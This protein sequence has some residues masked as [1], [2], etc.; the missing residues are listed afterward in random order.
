MKNIIE[1]YKTHCDEHFIDFGINSSVN[2]YDFTTLFCPAGMQ[3]YKSNFTDENFVAT[4]ANVQSCIRMND[5]DEIGDTTHLLYFNMIGLFSFR[6]LSVQQAIDFWM[7]FLCEKLELKLSYATIHPECKDWSNYYSKY[8]LKVKYQ[9]DCTWS[10]GDIGGYCTEL[11]IDEVE[12][13]NIV[14]PM[15]TCIDVGFGLERLDFF[16]NGKVI[17]KE[18]TL[19]ESAEKIISSGFKPSNTKQG[20]V[21][22][23][24]LREI[25]SLGL[26][27][28][29]SYFEQEVERQNKIKKKYERL[30]IRYPDESKEWWFDT[31]GVNI[32]D[33]Y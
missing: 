23:K 26:T 24:L 29:H 1:L 19:L 16:V 27:M 15:G 4:V 11:F 7:S 25:H 17:S 2:S 33:I 5:F 8:D 28:G 3:K 22:R 31:H 10:D 21:L 32:D 9:D 20:Y 14:N 18:R 13:G 6:D 30:K 12:I